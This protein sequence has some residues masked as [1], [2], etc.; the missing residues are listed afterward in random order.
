MKTS[1]NYSKLVRHAGSVS[2]ATL[3]SRALGYARDALVAYAFGGGYF[4]DAFYAAFRLPNLFR[5]ILG[6]GSLTAAY[7]PV[8]SEHAAHGRREAARASFQALFSGLAVLL[9][10][11]VAAGMIFAPQLTHLVALGFKQDPEKFALTVQLTRL[12][13]P[14]LLFVCLAA[15]ATAALNTYGRFFLPALAPAMLSVAEIAFVLWL[16]RFW[17]DPLEGLALS[18]VAGGMLHFGVLLPALARAGL[19]PGWRWQ[20]SHPDIGR[21]RTAV[22]PAVGGMS[23]DQVNAYV[24]TICA[25]FLVQGSVTALYNSN[26]L[27]Q[28]PLAVFGIALSTAALPAL[29]GH[30]ARQDWAEMK[31]TLNLSLRLVVFTVVPAMAGLIVLGAPAVELLFEHGRFT[32]R[33]TL[34]TYAALVG[35]GLGLPAFAAVK[36]LAG[37][38]YALKDTRT[39]V[40]VAT[41]CLFINMAG[42]YLFAFAYDGGVG[43]LAFATTL[44]SIANAVALGWLLR[45]KLG[46]L[47]GRRILKTLLQSAAAS[48][49]M[50]ALAGWIA[51]GTGGPLLWRVPAAVALGAG[52]YGALAAALRMEEVRHVWGLISRKET[53]VPAKPLQ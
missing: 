47:G 6:E 40:K 21:V 4:T 25:S 15:L 35:F 30:A 11:L 16:A 18:A 14:F 50:A 37:F 26:R 19:S 12:M 53:L 29:S 2:A 17:S 3:I 10:V 31:R 45:K 41:S 9:T 43:G 13:F 51:H 24:D 27:M 33:E 1:L 46:L 8:L 32:H 48:A 23:I 52:I 20:P 38:F 7:V 44:A 42:N 49:V 5:R 39:P 22:L 34:L 36:V 28:F